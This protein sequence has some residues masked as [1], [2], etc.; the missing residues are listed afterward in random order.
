MMDSFVRFQPGAVID[1]SHR[2]KWGNNIN[3]VQ[4]R[5]SR[6]AEQQLNLE[7]AAKHAASP[8]NIG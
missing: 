5:R 4:K 8:R 1:Y 6:D 7:R 3:C 2:Q